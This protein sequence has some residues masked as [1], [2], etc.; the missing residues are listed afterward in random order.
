MYALI[1]VSVLWAFSF[2]LIK[3]QLTGIDP[4]LVA[5][6]RLTFCFITFIPFALYSK[7][8]NKPMPFIALGIIQFGIMYWAYVQ[9]YQYLPG[10]LV[11]VFT[12][13][14]PFY[15]MIFNAIFDRKWSWLPLMPVLLSITGAA[16]I[17]FRAPEQAHYLQGFLILQTANIAFAFGQV[18]YR[19]LNRDDNSQHSS[20]MALMYLGAALFSALVVM[21]KG[22]Y[23]S[24]MAI[25]T[26][27][28]Y[29]LVYLGVIA[30]GIGFYGWNYGAKKANITQLAIM[31]NGYI[32]VAVILSLV[33]FGETA[34]INTLLLGGGVMALSLWW[35]VRLTQKT[36]SE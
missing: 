16:I 20:K 7:L 19:K 9:S 34:E 27:Q 28:W 36:A 18:G 4:S 26:N 13:F 8:P 15:V 29:V 31:N 35:S 6:I 10:Y 11:A 17:V 14:T 12:I 24:I 21:L 33:L 3:G 30:S 1:V 22:N 2:G 32:P 25:N 23:Q 5:A